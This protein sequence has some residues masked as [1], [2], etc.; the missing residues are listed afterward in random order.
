MQL[1]II[2]ADRIGSTRAPRSIVAPADVFGDLLLFCLFWKGL[3]ANES[4]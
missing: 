3:R 4:P 1:V 2:M